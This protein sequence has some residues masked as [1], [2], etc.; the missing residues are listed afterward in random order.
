[1]NH[2]SF[3]RQPQFS[4]VHIHDKMAKERKL[5]FVV[6]PGEDAVGHV[7]DAFEGVKH[8]RYT[9]AGPLIYN[10]GQPKESDAAYEL[11]TLTEEGQFRLSQVSESPSILG[12]LIEEAG[13][14]ASKKQEFKDF[15][16]GKTPT[17][18][19]ESTDELYGDTVRFI[20]NA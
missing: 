10:G 3:Q 19:V 14:R 1:M 8:T 12:Q 16:E 9:E 17:V 4:G 11:T 15:M 18:K 5:E 2:V 7:P 20:Y 13:G 6:T